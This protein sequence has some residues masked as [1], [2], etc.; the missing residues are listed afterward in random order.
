MEKLKRKLRMLLLS[1][2]GIAGAGGAFAQNTVTVSG[3]IRSAED[4]LPLIG[5]TVI[6]DSANATTTNVDGA[7][8]IS[9]APGSVLTFEYIGYKKEQLSVPGGSKTFRHDV[10]LKSETVSVDDVVVIAYGVRKKGTI[11]GSVSTVKAEKLADVP[12]ASFDQALQ[13]QAPGLTVL[14]NSGE[15]SAAASFQ[16]RGTNSINSGTSPLF[17]LDGMLISSTDFNAISPGDIE[18]VSVLKDASSTSIYGARAA[19]GVVVITTKRGR[20]SQNAQITYRMQLGISQLAQD[21]WNLMNTGERIAYEKEVGLDSGKNYDK[22]QHIDINWLDEVFTNAALLQSYEVQ[23]SGATEKVRYY[24]S[25][26]YFDQDGMAADSHFRRYNVRA[27]VEAQARKWLKLGTNALFA[28]EKIQQADA[29][30]YYT[31]T[32][33]SAARFMM[34]YWNPYKE[35]GSL[36]SVNDG[37]WKGQGENPL[38]WSEQNPAMNTKNKVIASLFAE[39]TLAKGLTIKSQ[40]GIDYTHINSKAF[41]MP[42]YKPN[43]EQ[44]LASRSTSEAYNLSITNTINYRFDIDRV[45]DFNFMLGQEGIDYSSNGFSVRTTGQKNDAL[46]DI[47][48]GTRARSWANNSTSYA[49][50]SFFGRGEYNYD[51]RYYADFSLRTD[52]S[53]RFGVKGRWANFWSVGLMWNLRNEKF[54]KNVKWLTN[55]QLAVSTGTSGNSSIPD[56]DHLA[57]VGGGLDYMDESGIYPLTKGNEN[58]EWEKLWT[59]NVALHLGFVNRINL[60]I[61]IYNKKTTNMLMAV[62]VPLADAGYGARWD[63]VGG[64]VNRGIEFNIN[65]DVIRTKDFTWNVSANVSYNQNKITELYNGVQEYVMSETG[66]KLVVGHSYGEFF[67]NRYAGVNSVNGDALWYDK[68][69]NITNEYRESDKVMVGKSYIAPWQGGFATSLA[70]KGLSLSAQ[71]SW[72]ADRWMVN[73]DRF[74]EESNGLFN[75]FNQSKRMLYDRWKNPGDITSIPRYGV[76][77]QMDTHLLEDA[78]FLRLKNLTLGYS[79]PKSLLDKTGVLGGVRIYA[80]AQ[81]LFTVTDF[82]GLDPESS[83]NIYKAQYPMPRQFT[84]GLELIF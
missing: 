9:L 79:F 22:L 26:N 19:N 15:P 24:V 82:S 61:E 28:H 68:D 56:F 48:S 47:S 52:G 23:V 36:A 69:G 32:P 33:I 3:T 74:F 46:T 13:G 84:F 55:A 42:S 45:H 66:T 72:V 76:S 7:Y 31:N 38:E 29:G 34:P 20:L 41:S 62:P 81:N 8:T 60:D 14:S 67:M 2:L 63:N 16:I 1:C 53:S 73:N 44:G 50:V 11:A 51:S 43:N 59:S 21:K 10:T 78:S 39:F 40:G 83:R 35:D 65:A 25:G 30:T 75:A 37:S 4:H 80:Q 77:P 58:L 18:S 17:I 12:A 27:N 6:A 71:F 49:Y 5:V 70:W 57:L 54:M 64:M